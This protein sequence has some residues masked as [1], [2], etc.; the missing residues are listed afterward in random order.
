MT[1]EASLASMTELRVEQRVM[2][3]QPRLQAVIVGPAEAT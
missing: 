1:S 2:I 3:G